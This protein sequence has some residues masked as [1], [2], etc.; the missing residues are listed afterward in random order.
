M[1]D[2]DFGLGTLGGRIA[3]GGADWLA[4]VRLATPRGLIASGFAQAAGSR[5][6]LGVITSATIRV[7]ALPAAP[8]QCAFVFPDFAAGLT[9]LQQARALAPFGA[10]LSDNA[11]NDFH[12]HLRAMDRHP[13][14]RWLARPA[15]GSRL[16]INFPDMASWLRFS[17]LARK[18][19]GQR[20][21][22]APQPHYRS[23]LLERGIM[24]E[25]WQLPA[26]W[27]QM[28]ALHAGLRTALEQAMRAHAPKDGAHGLVLGQMRG[29]RSDGADLVLTALY[30]RSLNDDVA[31][32]QA[33]RE[34]AQTAIVQ[35]TGA[36]VR[37]ATDVSRA[38]KLVLDPKGILPN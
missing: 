23:L 1:L 38:I 26:R 21:R 33:I 32:A 27:S 7:R 12:H 35:Q 13:L 22:P 8:W 30:P 36:P 5:G 11:E 25:R 15:T 28:S 14:L 10:R 3:L 34:A 2:E 9:A 19:G 24:V 20:Q 4:D 18:L 17:L 16:S 31:Q 37:P 6:T 29:S